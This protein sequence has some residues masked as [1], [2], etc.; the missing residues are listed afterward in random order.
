MFDSQAMQNRLQTLRDSVSRINKTITGN[1]TKKHFL[2]PISR[3]A[4][5]AEIALSEGLKYP[6]HATM[7]LR[8]AEYD[9]GEAERRLSFTQEMLAAYG[10]ELEEI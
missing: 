4:D 10:P 8:F 1:R 5:N 7:F 2:R 3:L 9:L 6:A